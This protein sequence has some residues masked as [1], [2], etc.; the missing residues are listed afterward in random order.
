[1]QDQSTSTYIL[2]ELHHFTITL[3]VKCASLT[4]MFL[5]NTLVAVFYTFYSGS[6]S[7]L[8]SMLTLATLCNFILSDDAFEMSQPFL[9]V[10]PRFLFSLCVGLANWPCDLQS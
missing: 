1:M 10:R 4:N 2:L 7:G 3:K 5:H 6:E 9:V 8:C